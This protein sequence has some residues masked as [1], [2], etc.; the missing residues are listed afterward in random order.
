MRNWSNLTPN[1]SSWLKAFFLG[2]SL[3]I[4]TSL[5]PQLHWLWSTLITIIGSIIYLFILFLGF[6]ISILPEFMQYLILGIINF[7]AS[8]ISNFIG[9]FSPLFALVSSLILLLP[10]PLI[11]WGHHYLYLLLDRYYPEI[12]PA[13]RIR[14]TG[15]FPGIISWWHGLY[16]LLIII[17]ALLLS[18]SILSIL[19][20]LSFDSSVGDFQISDLEISANN[21]INLWIRIAL[22]IFGQP[23]YRPFLRL[24]I[25]IITAAYLY[26]FE[27]SFRQHLI[28]SASSVGDR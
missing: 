26:Q 2:S 20:W 10:I 6:L 16:G 28:S 9:L 21:R 24:V 1:L 17:L 27:F 8:I 7:I 22:M 13:P 3:I 11:A 12:L 14:V 4:V 15:Y 23:I 5:I 25:W 19:P 18:D